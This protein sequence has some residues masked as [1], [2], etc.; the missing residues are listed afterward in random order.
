MSLT[1][2][3]LFLINL[4]FWS[5]FDK[6]VS[7]CGWSSFITATL[8]NEICTYA[9]FVDQWPITHAIS[10]GAELVIY[11]LAVVTTYIRIFV[12]LYNNWTALKVYVDFDCEYIM[13]EIKYERQVDDQDDSLQTPPPGKCIVSVRRFPMIK[14]LV[15][16]E[17]RTNDYYDL[18]FGLP[19][20]AWQFASWKKLQNAVCVIMH[21]QTGLH[22]ID[23]IGAK[24]VEFL[25]K[26][27]LHMQEICCTTSYCD[28]LWCY[29][30]YLMKILT[31][32]NWQK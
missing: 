13:A 7:I 11:N 31:G 20:L 17:N 22:Y 6:A 14:Y 12:S 8:E 23:D 2:F 5:R 28:M 30:Y 21:V 18:H 27:M 29:D 26:V 9:L 25:Y 4:H 24:E 19:T 3:L 32:H 16:I 1:T 15:Y 10:S